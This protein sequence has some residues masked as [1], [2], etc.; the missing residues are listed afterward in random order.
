[1]SA[2]VYVPRD[3]GS[4][5]LGAGRVADAIAAEARRRG[6]EIRLVRNGSRGLYWL[7]P[8]VEVDTARGRVGYGPVSATDVTTLF[9]VGFSRGGEH[10]LSLGAVEEIPYLKRQERLTFA[11]MG[12]IDPVSV[13]DYVAH[14]GYRGLDRALA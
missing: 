5:S 8:L 1:M 13:D 11:R 14:G 2:T 7:E 6:V 9:D 12:I 10:R 3:S 4:V